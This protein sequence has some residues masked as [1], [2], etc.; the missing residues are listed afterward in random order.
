MKLLEE[1]LGENLLNLGESGFL[2]HMKVQTV[3]EK[4]DNFD[5]ISFK[6]LLPF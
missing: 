1:N 2:K 4:M 6:K 5:S 3:G